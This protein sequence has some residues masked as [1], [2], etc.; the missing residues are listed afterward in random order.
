[1]NFINRNNRNQ[2]TSNKLTS[3][4]GKDSSAPAYDSRAN[5]EDDDYEKDGFDRV[6]V[7]DLD[8]A[9]AGGGDGKHSVVDIG[10]N[11]N[12]SLEQQS[13]AISARLSHNYALPQIKPQ[14]SSSMV[15]ANLSRSA[16]SNSHQGLSRR[17]M[18]TIQNM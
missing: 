4:R 2:T 5:S 15:L 14:L 9:Y 16:V 8:I 12:S 1:M 6:S 10:Q 7:E 11:N 13:A 18:N 17:S 3:Q